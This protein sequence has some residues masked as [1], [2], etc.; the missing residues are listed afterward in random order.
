MQ[1]PTRLQPRSCRF[2][3]GVRPL[4]H[5]TYWASHATVHLPEQR[6]HAAASQA[7]GSDAVAHCQRLMLLARQR[8]VH[9]GMNPWQS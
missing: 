8:L 1:D 3:Y 4:R 7:C 9:V 2:R 6:R 5:A